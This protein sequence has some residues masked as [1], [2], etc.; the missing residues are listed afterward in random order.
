EV[1]IAVEHEE[2]A[3][4]M[5][6]GAF[7]RTAG[8][9][10]TLAIEHTAHLQ[11]K[12]RTITDG[13]LDLLAEGAEAQDDLADTPL[14]Q[15]R[16]LPVNEGAACHRHERFGQRRGDRAKPR[17]PTAGQHCNGQQTHARTTFV[18]S[19]SNLKRTSC[20][21]ASAMVWRSRLRSLA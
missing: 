21:P 4:Q 19:K 10:R 12:L 11:A 20:S 7:Q 14:C 8:S 13:G 16:E 1:G 5:W 6:Q 2:S 9:E 17:C 15:Q 18:P 3:T